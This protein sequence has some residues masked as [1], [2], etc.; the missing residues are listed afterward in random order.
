MY[1][2]F[3]ALFDFKDRRFFK[4]LSKRLRS[5]SVTLLDENLRTALIKKQLIFTPTE[6]I[7]FLSIKIQT[8][9]NCFLYQEPC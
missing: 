7:I 5:V 9:E 2:L 6:E 1:L 3:K 4:S 8:F